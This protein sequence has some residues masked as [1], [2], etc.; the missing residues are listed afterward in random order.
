M[1]VKHLF[2]RGVGRWVEMAGGARDGG[3]FNA[4][5]G[6]RKDSRADSSQPMT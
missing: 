4:K 6:A 2:R 5:I 1:T 3:E